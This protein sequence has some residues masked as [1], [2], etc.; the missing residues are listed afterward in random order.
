MMLNN[1]KKKMKTLPGPP[2]GTLE[3]NYSAPPTGTML[4]SFSLRQ[5]CTRGQQSRDNNG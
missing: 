2:S 3:W 4:Y 5:C 1:N